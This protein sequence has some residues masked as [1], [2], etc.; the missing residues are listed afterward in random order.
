MKSASLTEKKDAYENALQHIIRDLPDSIQWSNDGHWICF[1]PEQ[2]TLPA[3]GWKIHLSVIPV[4][5][6][7]L[8]QRITPI[9]TRYGVMWKTVSSGLKLIETSNGSTPLPQTGKCVTI[10]ARSDEQFMQL[11]EEMYTCTEG[12]KG[13]A[14]PTDRVYRGSPCVFIAMEPS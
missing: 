3:Q 11:L 1:K 12:L 8:L 5:G 14:I 2:L 4:Q 10:Y 9:L 6:A 7:E 13:P